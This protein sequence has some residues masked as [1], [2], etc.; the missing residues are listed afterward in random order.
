MGLNTDNRCITEPHPE[1]RGGKKPGPLTAWPR[2]R[3]DHRRRWNGRASLSGNRHRGGVPPEEPFT[4]DPLY[5]HRTGSGEEDSG[6]AGAPPPDHPRGRDKGTGADTNRGSPHED[7]R[8][9]CRLLSDPPRI[10]SRYRCRCGRLRLGTGG[11]CR[12]VHGDENGHRRTE[13][14]PGSDQPDPRQFYR[15]DLSRLFG[16]AEVVPERQDG[17]YGKSDPGSLPCGKTG[18]RK[19]TVRSSR[20][21][22]SAAAKGRTRSTGSSAKPW[23]A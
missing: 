1:G 5:R 4:P 18:G 13:R 14:V 19:R 21:L 10:Q 7:P 12:P 16:I 20:S 8:E 22:S 3:D 9:S 15:P 17:G 6:R 11:P 23:T 2:P